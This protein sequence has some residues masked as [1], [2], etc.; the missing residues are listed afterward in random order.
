MTKKQ[1][2]SALKSAYAA[3]GVDI[4][5]KSR[6]FE[7]M[8]EAV[9]STYTPAVLGGIGSFG[10][11]FALDERLQA[12]DP[13]LVASTDGVG[14]KTM[15]AE[16]MGRYETIGHDVVN[17]CINDV[18]V[19]GAR[20]LFFLDY[21]ASGKLDPDMVV[22]IVESCAAA[23][24]TSGCVLIGGETAEMPGVYR[25][26]TFDLVG[27][28]VGWVERDAIVDGHSVQ[29]GDVCLG[30][31]SSGLHTNG[32]SLARRVFADTGWETVL[33]EL[34][35]PV[36]EVLLTPHR[37][38]LNEFEALVSAGVTVKAMAH[39][40]GGSFPDN[41]PRVLPPGVGVQIDRAAWEVPVIFR[42]IQKR[43][44]VDEIEMYQVFNM[45]VG[46]VLLVAAQE[47]ERAL[48]ALSGEALVIGRAIP[49]DGTGP[50]VRL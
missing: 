25:P 14:T 5:A 34:G 31:P 21:I 23:C 2:P 33:P 24:R 50:R 43:G 7:R 26:G 17:H 36:G 44:Q 42:L 45:G 47:V 3:A 19:Q 9:Q 10:G 16:M 4:E 35:R 29:P 20:P 8:R 48:A 1:E 32:Y 41:L 6:T 40:T 22:A 11:L 30:L 27:T 28:L 15:I 13:V 49:W 37:A 38:Y 46:L 39:I 12:R 18:L